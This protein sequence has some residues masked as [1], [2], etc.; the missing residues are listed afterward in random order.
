LIIWIKQSSLENQFLTSQFNNVVEIK[1]IIRSDPILKSGQVFGSNRRSDEHSVLIKLTQVNDQKINLPAR[2][3]YKSNISL[4]IDQY[5]SATVR[6]IKTR[7]IK[8][9][10]LAVADGSISI[11]SPPRKIFHITEVIRNN[12]RGHSDGSMS[13]SLVPG[14]VLG[15][16]SLQSNEFK[17]Q[18]Q[19]VGLSHLTAVSGANFV[20]VASFLLWLLQFLVK[21]LKH[22]L[23]VVLLVLFL[24][25]FLVRPTPSV[26]RAAVMTLVVLIA[27]FRG[28]NSRGIASL[29]AAITLLILLD[30]FQAIDPGFALSV[31]ATS[32]ILLLSPIIESRLEN[33]FKL[34]WLI[35]SIAIPVSATILCLPVILLLSKEFS[36]AT[37]PAN[38]LV[39]PVIA[40]ITV[41]G[42]LSAVITPFIPIIG[43]MLFKTASAFANYIVVISGLMDKFPS[44]QFNDTRFYIL[45]I[46]VLLILLLRHRQKVALIT[47]T[48]LLTQIIFVT[49]SWPGRD[50]QLANCDVGQGDAMVINLG[51]NSAIVVDTGPDSNAIDRC[52]RALRIKSIPLMILTHFHSDHVGAI[53]GV[54]KNRTISQVWI[55]NLNQPESTYERVIKELSGIKVRSVSKGESYRFPNGDITVEVL[56]P[57]A[58]EINFAQLP[59]DG[60]KINNSSIS[61]ILRTKHLS[62]FAGGDIEPEVQELITNSGLLS[63]I[64]ILKVSHHGS[65]YQHLPMLDILKPEVAIISVGSENT[66]GHPDAEFLNEL[67][68]RSISVWRT[69]HSG[70]ISVAPSNK[71]RVTGKEWW[72]IRWG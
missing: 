37:I 27:R 39:A 42:F 64:D 56:W 61:I 33:L 24:F 44:F 71:I 70:G 12:F 60:S 40:P 1:A 63:D 46:I 22:R 13:S 18:M 66:Y 6:L 7:E 15:D 26:L 65:A 3:K 55:S 38:I 52:L 35:E 4:Q 62:L 17:E 53:T 72:K 32:G 41:L 58:N 50:W 31:L 16:T 9:A 20:L 54:K 21:R 2:L 68:K 5:I 57:Q 23:I 47:A 25:I 43:L 51:K 45:I 49:T 8:V 67:G 36:L 48:L 11:L 34:K 19:K 59:G 30:P 69:D 10:A 29:G 14:L 28:E